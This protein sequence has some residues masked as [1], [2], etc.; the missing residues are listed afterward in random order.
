MIYAFGAYE[1]DT[2]VFEVRHLGE[3]CAVE[4]QVFNVLAYLAEHRDRV[5]S[6]VELLEKLWP[7]RVVSD[8]TLTSRLKAARKAVGDDGKAQHVIRTIHGRGYRFVADLRVAVG[9]GGTAVPAAP[10]AGAGRPERFVGR[11]AELGRLDR[12]FAIAAEGKRQIVFIAGDAGAGKTTL[13]EAFL[14]RHRA[15]AMHVA[16]GQCVEHRGS[17]EPYMPLLDAIGRLCRGPHG[18]RTIELLRREA[19][20]WLLQL[21]SLLRDGETAGLAARSS[22]GERMLRELGMLLERMSEEMPLVLVVEDLHWSDSATLEALDLVAR[23]ADRARLLILGTFRPPL[24]AV[25]SELRA[26][27]HCQLIELPLL[28]VREIDDYLRASLPGA[29]F[30]RELAALLHERTSGNPLFAGNLLG[31]WIARG[32]IREH[33]GE[34]LLEASIGTLETDVPESLQQL[35]ENGVAAL[36]GEA[37]RLLETASVLGCE[38]SIA[39]LAATLAADEEEVERRCEALAR[40]ARFLAPAGTA[41][42]G[43]TATSRFAFRHDLYVDVLY[44]RIP[45]VRRARVHRQAGLVL[46]RAWSGRERERAAELALHFCRADDPPRAIRYLDIAAEQALQRSAYREAAL[47]LAAALDLLLAASAPSPDRDRAELS[48][49]SRLAPALIATSGWADAEAETNYHRAC[50]LAHVTGERAVLSQMLYGTALM[51]EYRGDYRRAEKIV[52]ERLAEDGDAAMANAVESHDLLACSMLHQGRYA[53]AVRCAESAIAAAKQTPEPLDFGTVAVLVQAHGWMAIALVFMGRHDDA[54][55]HGA[56]ALAMAETRGDEL[57]RANA[58]VQAAF[59]YFHYRDT[60]TCRRLAAAA[61]AIARECRLPFH[62]ACARILLGWCLSQE[63]A[64]EEALREVQAGIRTSLLAGAQIE[65]PLFLAVLAECLDRAGHRERA[66]EAL[67]EAFAHAGRSRSYF[68]VP[69]LYRMSA[70]LLLARG[71]GETARLALEQAEVMAREQA[72]PLFVARVAA[73]FERIEAQT[74]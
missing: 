19:P 36:D 7:D 71:D 26:R 61:E 8:A 10:A 30:T 4:P 33:E 11:E 48:F 67:D 25:T 15:T 70:D 60:G 20:S 43:G 44:E 56:I 17:G 62:L 73:S 1:L 31:S 46:E 12:A 16:R 72:S 38:L 52:R 21:P 69:E 32:L 47:H 34:W 18:A 40:G 37:Q 66:L 3:V 27:G 59:V 74:V 68:Y 41:E 49:R 45:E 23:H 65:A 14:A 39:F 6:K 42:W 64:H 50:A 58:L 13:V 51:Y 9:R 54:I 24:L 22:S 35:I 28:A 57:A 5:V 2:R 63:G 53:E 55:A 29:D